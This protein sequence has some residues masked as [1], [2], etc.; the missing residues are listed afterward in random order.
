MVVV[1]ITCVCVGLAMLDSVKVEA[2]GTRMPL[3]SVGN[4]T[5]RSP[6]LLAV[7]VHDPA[8]GSHMIPSPS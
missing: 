6:S 7:T 3:V 4:V 5:A 8:V 2:Y 1:M